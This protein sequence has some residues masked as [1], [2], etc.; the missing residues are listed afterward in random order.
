M[1]ATP[2]PLNCKFQQGDTWVIK[3]GLVVTYKL[4]E[5]FNFDRDAVRAW[6]ESVV[7]NANYV[8]GHQLGINFLIHRI[9]LKGNAESGSGKEWNSCKGGPFK[10]LDSFAMWLRGQKFYSKRTV[11]HLMA[12]CF[13]ETGV[14]GVAYRNSL[15]S[16][17]GFNAGISNYE[18]KLTWVSFAH[19]TGH[20]LGA[21][22]APKSGI[23]SR[24]TKYNGIFQF[25]A[26]VSRNALCRTLNLAMFLQKCK[27]IVT[28]GTWAPTGSPST[29]P[30]IY[31]TPVPTLKPTLQVLQTL[32]S[33][34]Q[35]TIQ[36]KKKKKRKKKS[37]RKKKKK[38]K[39]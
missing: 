2:S 17:W 34:P 22:D 3:L 26:Q 29:S 12:D 25:N 10:R 1:D 39:K 5:R 18:D 38:K 8:F 11:W 27:G 15:C 35:T 13:F 23:M 4:L 24:G 20:I 28:R 31:P 30:T 16:G 33:Q 19:E 9:I 6:V 7:A 21:K 37:K 32:P 14:I 36:N